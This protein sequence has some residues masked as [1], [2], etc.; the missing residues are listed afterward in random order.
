MNTRCNETVQYF[1]HAGIQKPDCDATNRL[2][3]YWRIDLN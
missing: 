1:T 3:R 2:V